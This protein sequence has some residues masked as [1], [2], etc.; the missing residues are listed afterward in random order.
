MVYTSLATSIILQSLMNR[1]SLACQCHLVEAR[2][3]AIDKSAVVLDSFYFNI[4]R[5]HCTAAGCPQEFEKKIEGCLG[6]L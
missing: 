4:R 2:S 6:L 1:T 3:S 5:F